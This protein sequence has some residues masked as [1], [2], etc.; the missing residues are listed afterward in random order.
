MENRNARFLADILPMSNVTGGSGAAAL[1][2]T[3]N[4]TGDYRVPD[5]V[6]DL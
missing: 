2:P 3:F 4:I 5:T 1:F 6:M